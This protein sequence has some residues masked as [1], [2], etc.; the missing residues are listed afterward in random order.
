MVLPPV[1]LNRLTISQITGTVSITCWIVVFIPQIYKIFK[2]KSARGLSLQFIVIWLLGDIFNVVG[3]I[4]QNLLFTVIL[5]AIYYTFADILLF[6]QWIW[7]TKYC[8]SRTLKIHGGLRNKK[9]DLEYGSIGNII[10]EDVTRALS[11]GSSMLLGGEEIHP[12]L[13]GDNNMISSDNDE[14]IQE[15]D[16]EIVEVFNTDNDTDQIESIC[17]RKT[18]Q[19][20]SGELFYNSLCV[21]VV[22]IVGV[23]SWYM[24]YCSNYYKHNKKIK[25]S[26]PEPNVHFN[27]E[28]QVFGYISA[29]L[30]LCSRI[31]QILLNYKRKSCDGVSFLFFLFACL[32]N[33]TFI[34]SILIV[35]IDSNYIEMNFSWLL[36]SA[37]TLLMDLTIFTQFFIYN[38]EKVIL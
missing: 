37:G 24:S 29:V 3:A 32:G 7:Y 28:A 17:T 4:K 16:D 2:E 38:K 13:G 12:L 31:P 35:S 27:F 25:P 21:I 5:L 26:L 6:L 19:T 8:D 22:I 15:D 30:Y 23:L 14:V 10:T 36:G 20:Q 1:V 11:R 18:H 9:R 33:I 34:F